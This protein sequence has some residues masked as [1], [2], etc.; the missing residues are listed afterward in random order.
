MYAYI[1]L[2][3]QHHSDD[4]KVKSF[5]PL[6]SQDISTL[7]KRECYCE[8]C[9]SSHNLPTS[10]PT[11]QLCLFCLYFAGTLLTN[12]EFMYLYDVKNQFI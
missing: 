7:A 10:I 5:W 8:N 1:H 6:K 2:V 11:L 3:L 12:R 9:W 4:L